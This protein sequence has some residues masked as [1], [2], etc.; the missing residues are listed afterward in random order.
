MS[1]TKKQALGQG[2]AALLGPDPTEDLKAKKSIS[3]DVVVEDDIADEGE[4]A[5]II[6]LSQTDS[7]SVDALV[8]GKFQPRQNFDQSELEALAQSIREHGVLQ[9]VLVRPTSANQYEI[10][11]GER[12]WRA[13]KIA[14]LKEIPAIVKANI[15][16]RQALEIAIL[17]NIQRN[18]LTIMEEARGYHRLME[19]FGYTQEMLS[20]TLGKSRSH[21]A[22]MIRLLGLEEKAQQYL[23]T[24]KI[25]FGHARAL[26]SLYGDQ[27]DYV[28]ETIEKKNLTVRQTERLVRK[29]NTYGLP[30]ESDRA[31]HAEP[32]E[33]SSR[34]RAASGAQSSMFATTPEDEASCVGD[35][36][37][38]ANFIEKCV[39]G[40]ALVFS[41]ANEHHVRIKFDRVENLD[42]LIMALHHGMDYILDN[43]VD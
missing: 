31:E 35:Y 19:E 37:N 32:A 23:D 9:P 22:N 1:S 15:D 5:E 11:A 8:P 18:D 34:P 20:Q 28:L 39:G 13:S 40:K 41:K 42:R 6:T 12:R 30:H 24:K 36:R 17:E 26:L 3:A 43:H 33:Q 7:L 27:L 14:G 21:V 16:D 25:S 29:I 2:L 4:G 38:M 10:I